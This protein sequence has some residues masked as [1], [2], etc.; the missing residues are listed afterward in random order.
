MSGYEVHTNGIVII[1]FLDEGEYKTGQSLYESY[2]KPTWKDCPNI[3]YFYA[4]TKSK[5]IGILNGVI[6]AAKEQSFSPI[7]HLESHGSI[8]GIST[9]VRDGENMSWSELST[10]LVEINKACKF[11][12]IL[13]TSSCHG[14]NVISQLAP[15]AP[16][17]FWGNIGP[18]GISTIEALSI[19]F[20]AFY[21]SFLS[22]YKFTNAFNIMNSRFKY[23]HERYIFTPADYWFIRLYAEFLK[24]EGSKSKLLRRVDRLFNAIPGSTRLGRTGQSALRKRLLAGLSDHEGFFEKFRQEFFMET[25]CPGTIERFGITYERVQEA[26]R[27][28]EP[29]HP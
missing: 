18:Q 14:A 16:A 28:K 11:N 27:R 24:T 7:V 5:L 17:P 12:L 3:F 1:D 19:D 15:P 8:Y 29:G 22:D 21:R 26:L 13:V 2:I 9:S 25:D 6:A 4:Q 20:G 10:Y 23:K